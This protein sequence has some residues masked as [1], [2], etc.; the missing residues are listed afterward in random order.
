MQVCGSWPNIAGIYR[1]YL[2]LGK[3]HMVV[4]SENRPDGEI[5]GVIQAQR[6]ASQGA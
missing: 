1:R 4:T 2:E 5:R 6:S 3:L